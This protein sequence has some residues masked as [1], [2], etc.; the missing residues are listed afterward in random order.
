MKTS[1]PAITGLAT[2]TATAALRTN[3]AVGSSLTTVSNRVGV[4]RPK[5]ELRGDLIPQVREPGLRGLGILI[6]R[7]CV[8]EVRILTRGRWIAARLEI[9][10]PGDIRGVGLNRVLPRCVERRSKFLGIR[11]ERERLALELAEQTLA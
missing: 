3:R 8:G 11:E 2:T 7:L 10:P 6:D 9:G 5:L 4:L 1:E